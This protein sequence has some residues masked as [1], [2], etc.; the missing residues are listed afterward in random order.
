M[1]QEH[2]KH[3]VATSCNHNNKENYW[4]IL[5]MDSEAGQGVCHDYIGVNCSSCLYIGAS[6]NFAICITGCAISCVF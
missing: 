1:Q 4:K 6:T 2:K 5:K 3:I